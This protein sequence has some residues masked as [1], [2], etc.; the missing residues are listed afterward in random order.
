M[1]S[2]PLYDDIGSTYGITR[3][4]DPQLPRRSPDTPGAAAGD[5]PG[6]GLRHR[7]L[8]LRAGRPGRAMAR[9]RRLRRHA[10]A[11]PAP[12]A[13]MWPGR[14][15]MPRRRSPTAASTAPSARWRSTTFRGSMRRSGRCCFSCPRFGAVRP[16]HRLPGPRCAISWLGHYFPRMRRS[17]QPHRRTRWSARCAGRGLPS[18][19]SFPFHITRQLQDLFLY[20]GKDRPELYLDPAVRANISS[21]APDVR[22]RNC[23]AGWARWRWTSGKSGRRRDPW[24]FQRGWRLRL[25]HRQQGGCR[26]RPCHDGVAATP[27]DRPCACC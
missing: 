19:T 13:R 18:R 12:S 11:G 21:F 23:E 10:G 20:S 4:A 27:D 6:R 9:R 26:T 16:V 1:K 5:L 22:P 2:E 8:H 7:Q 14:A 24:L 3:R 25:R 15:P 17:I